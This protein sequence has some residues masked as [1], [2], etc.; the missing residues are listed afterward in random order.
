M[1]SNTTKKGTPL[2]VPKKSS[3]G[4]DKDLFK[5][6]VKVTMIVYVETKMSREVESRKE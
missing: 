5:E 4:E 2:K 3:G 6:D 1:V